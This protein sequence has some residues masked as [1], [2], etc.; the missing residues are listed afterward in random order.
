MKKVIGL[1][2]FWS[3]SLPV[4]AQNYQQAIIDSL[5]K[6]LSISKIDTSNVLTMVKLADQYK[7]SNVD[8]SLFY[9]QKALEALRKLNIPGVAIPRPFRSS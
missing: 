7:F 3:F 4:F 1:F 8:S 5:K 9:G 6:E 2:L